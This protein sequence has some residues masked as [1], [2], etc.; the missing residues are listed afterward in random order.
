MFKLG[1]KPTIQ[2]TKKMVKF[3]QKTEKQVWKWPWDSSEKRQ[4]NI[5]KG[6]LT[7][8]NPMKEYYIKVVYCWFMTCSVLM[9]KTRIQQAVEEIIQTMKNAVNNKTKIY[10]RQAAINQLVD[11]YM[12]FLNPNAY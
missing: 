1:Y 12:G 10:S 7:F 2:D 9:R 8:P 11:M 4:G 6:E 3:K 5:S